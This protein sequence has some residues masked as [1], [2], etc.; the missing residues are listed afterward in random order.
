MKYQPRYLFKQTIL[1]LLTILLLLQPACTSKIKIGGDSSLTRHEEALFSQADMHFQAKNYDKA[2]AAYR[3]FLKEYPASAKAPEAL[4]KIGIIYQ[5]QGDFQQAQKSFQQLINQYPRSS[6]VMAAHT[7]QLDALNQQGL[8]QD[9][10]AQAPEIIQ[11]YPSQADTSGLYATLG[12]AYMASGLSIDAFE[13]YRRGMAKATPETQARLLE[14]LKQSLK[15]LSNDELA[16]LTQ[17]QQTPMIQGYLLSQL[18]SNFMEQE[19]YEKARATLTTLTEQYP[20]HDAAP[21]ARAQL[22]QL[23]QLAQVKLDT[24]GCLLPLS[25]SHSYFGNRGLRGLEL[26][27]SE[28]E[29][30]ANGSSFKVVIRDT[31]SDPRQAVEATRDLVNQNVVGII[32]PIVTAEDAAQVAEEYRT[33]IITITQ[34]QGITDIGDYVF[35]NFLTPEMQIKTLMPF[36]KHTLMIN[37]FAILYPNEAYGKKFMN[38]FW[39]EVI[40]SGGKVVALESYQPA[41]TDFADNIKKLAGLYY[42]IPKEFQDFDPRFQITENGETE[43]SAVSPPSSEEDPV[44]EDDEEEELEPIVDFDAIFIPDAPSKAGLIIPQ[45]SFHDINDVYLLG[46][47]L[48]HS[49]KMIAMAKDYAQGAIMAD[50]FFAERKSAVVKHFVSLY[51]ETYGEKPGFI[52]AVV[53]DTAIMLFKILHQENIQFRSSLKDAIKRVKDYNGVTGLTSFDENGEVHKNLTILKIEGEK[54]VELPAVNHF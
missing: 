54:F 42:E 25:G 6:L 30:K 23:N 45:L 28:W 48:W 49:E 7:G 37:K 31:T 14:K 32:G 36:I 5:F 10:V 24:I 47:N 11:R 3:A 15:H 50:V 22:E 12:D 21:Q 26:A 2:H 8:Y 38:L 40:A 41:Q 18:A 4:L 27:L 20:D 13:A 33:P 43:L 53:Y 44:L 39:D 19:D 1:P 16:L 34:K 29:A 35:R 9:V 17:K 51:E 52:E 46:T